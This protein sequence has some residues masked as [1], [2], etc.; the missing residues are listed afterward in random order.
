MVPIGSEAWVRL[1]RPG[2]GSPWATSR[3]GMAGSGARGL[4]ELEA[5]LRGRCGVAKVLACRGAS[6]G[7]WKR[8]KLARGGGRPRARSGG[9]RACWSATCKVRGRHGRG[10]RV[11]VGW[12]G[13]AGD[14]RRVSGGCVPAG[15]GC[16]PC[17]HAGCSTAVGTTGLRQL[18]ARGGARREVGDM[19]KFRGTVANSWT[20]WF[21]VLLLVGQVT[22]V[23]WHAHAMAGQG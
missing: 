6:S 16:A 9:A 8:A 19:G 10:A 7:A 4:G 5:H 23:E 15:G 18:R 3:T 13:R 17:A 22:V 2:R 14:G 21:I 12:R 11:V 1:N 20:C